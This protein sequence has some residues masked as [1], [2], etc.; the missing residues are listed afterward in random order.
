MREYFQ[1]LSNNRIKSNLCFPLALIHSFTSF[2]L[3]LNAEMRKKNYD[4]S[5]FN[6]FR[7]RKNINT[8]LLNDKKH[9]I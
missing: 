4:N 1:Y 3:R 7:F 8:S 6:R 2:H 5:S 9:K